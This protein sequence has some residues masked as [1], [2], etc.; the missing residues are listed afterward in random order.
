MNTIIISYSDLPISKVVLFLFLFA[1]MAKP[2]FSTSIEYSFFVLARIKNAF[3]R[4]RYM[5]V[6]KKY[7]KQNYIYINKFNC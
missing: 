6:A 1:S 4:V 2:E 7:L 5:Y 3:L